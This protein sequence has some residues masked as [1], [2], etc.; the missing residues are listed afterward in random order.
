M[1]VALVVKG[2]GIENADA[3]AQFHIGLDHVRIDR[4]EHDVGRQ[5]LRRE[6]V[7]DGRAAGEG[8][9]VGDDRV[10]S[11][12]LERELALR[13]ERVFGRHHHHMMPAVAGQRD[14]T[15]VVLDALGGHRDV[16][17]AI[18]HHGG[19]CRRRALHDRQPHFRIAALEFTDR[20][21]QR[22]ARLGVGCGDGQAA[23]LLVGEFGR[24]LLEVF[25]LLQQALDHLQHRAA[26]LGQLG[27]ALAEAHENLHPELVFQ[28][29]DLLGDAGLRGMQG[30]G[31]GCQVEPLANGFAH[32]AQLLEVHVADRPQK[33]ESLAGGMSLSCIMQISII[34][35]RLIDAGV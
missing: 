32:I 17:L 5:A 26:R 3:Q 31:G 30:G 23:R 10:G 28:F 16:G 27:D 13:Q 25:G 11:Q 33:H 29:A 7:V 2:D 15:R 12:P 34:T 8:A 22:V 4:R 19:D 6:G 35:M 1:A 21:W 20:R 14:Q 9:V 24:G 18:D